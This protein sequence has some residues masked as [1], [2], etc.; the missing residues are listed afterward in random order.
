MRQRDLPRSGQ[1]LNRCHR[2]CGFFPDEIVHRQKDLTEGNMLVRLRDHGRR[3]GE[4]PGPSQARHESVGG[5]TGWPPT[6]YA[7]GS[8]A[9]ASRTSTTS[10]R[11]RC[12]TKLRITYDTQLHTKLSATNDTQLQEVAYE[13]ARVESHRCSKLRITGDTGILKRILDEWV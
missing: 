7:A 12:S 4:I 2:A 5:I 3:G 9:S 11:T 1:R 6:R 13:M 8:M 10:S